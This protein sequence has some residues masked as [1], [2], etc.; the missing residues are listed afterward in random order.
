L[1][2]RS[3]GIKNSFLLKLTISLFLA[4]SSALFASNTGLSACAAGTMTSY[5]PNGCAIG[6]LDYYNFAY[7]VANGNTGPG[8]GTINV[9]PTSQGFSFGP[10][11]NTSNQTYQFEIDYYILI[12]PSP[13]IT[14]DNL[15]LD[16]SGD[17]TIDEIF[18]NDQ[19]LSAPPSPTCIGQ[20]NPPTLEVGNGNGLPNSN[21]ITFANPAQTSQWVALFFTVAPGASFDGLEN[22]SIVSIAPEPASTGLALIGMLTLAAGYK[23]RKR[24]TS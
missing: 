5:A 14:G 10:V 13:V 20:P 21:S 9:T 15:R 3:L 12:D 23:L 1:E 17:I 6:I 8:A 18:C 22:D 7:T 2:V 4:G 16:V 11:N 24:R 19:T